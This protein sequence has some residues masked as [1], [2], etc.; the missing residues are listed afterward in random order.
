MKTVSVYILVL[1]DSEG[2]SRVELFFFSRG[3]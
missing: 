3:D 1:A 2:F